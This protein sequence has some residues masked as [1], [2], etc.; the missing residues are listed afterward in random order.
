M[1]EYVSRNKH[2]IFLRKIKTINLQKYW[3]TKFIAE[4]FIIHV[5]FEHGLILSL[6]AKSCL[7]SPQHIQVKIWAKE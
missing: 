3:N 4:L 1:D 2:N 7:A 6:G 5:N